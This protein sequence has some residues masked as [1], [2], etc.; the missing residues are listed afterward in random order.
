MKENGSPEMFSLEI[1]ESANGKRHFFY[2]E[3]NLYLTS[4]FSEF[5]QL[6]CCLQDRLRSGRKSS[7][8]IFGM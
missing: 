8:E 5:C 6:M 2:E 7:F 4:T 1:E 3:T